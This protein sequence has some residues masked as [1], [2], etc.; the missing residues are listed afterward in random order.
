MGVRVVAPSNDLRQF[1]NSVDLAGIDL[2]R[3]DHFVPFERLVVHE[4]GTRLGS[5]HLLVGLTIVSNPNGLI[6]RQS[7]IDSDDWPSAAP[8]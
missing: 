1:A 8:L 5:L 7:E 2:S 4:Q 3:H 6:I